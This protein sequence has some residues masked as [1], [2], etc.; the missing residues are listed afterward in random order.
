MRNFKANI[1]DLTAR[2][3]GMLLSQVRYWIFEHAGGNLAGPKRPCY[4][5]LH[6]CKAKPPTEFWKQALGGP[7]P[8]KCFWR[9][10]GVLDLPL[11]WLCP[12]PL[13]NYC[14]LPLA[15]LPQAALCSKETCSIATLHIQKGCDN[16][17]ELQHI[18]YLLT[19]LHWHQPKRNGKPVGNVFKWGLFRVAFQFPQ[20]LLWGKPGFETSKL[21]RK[22]SLIFCR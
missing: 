19:Q 14:V 2:N 6:E 10:L 17:K 22:K 3:S 18:A 5:S 16:I 4:H 13:S 12:V 1:S 7:C 15:H 20:K 11:C 9:V 21:S 8:H